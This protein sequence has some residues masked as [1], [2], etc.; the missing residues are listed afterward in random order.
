MIITH[1]GRH[2]NRQL[3][4]WQSVKATQHLLGQT[5]TGPFDV[6]ASRGVYLLHDYTMQPVYVGQAGGRARP[7]GPRFL[8]HCSDHLWGSWHFYSWFAVGASKQDEDVSLGTMLNE[9]EDL[10]IYL[11]IPRLNRK[12]GITEGAVEV[13]QTFRN[14]EGV[15]SPFPIYSEMASLSKRLEQLESNLGAVK[16]ATA[17][18]SAEQL[19]L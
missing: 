12:K 7:M 14:N 11:L 4:D 15:F 6:F 18:S 19:P 2:W 16:N 13:A 9:L 17:Q 10:F 8:E 5:E 3:T 1:Y